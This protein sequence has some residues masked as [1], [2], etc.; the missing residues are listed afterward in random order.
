MKVKGLL[1]TVMV[2]LFSGLGLSEVKEF[3]SDVKVPAEAAMNVSQV[4]KHQSKVALYQ[5]LGRLAKQHHLAIY[6]PVIDTK[7]KLTYPCLSKTV[8]SQQVPAALVT[9]SVN[10]M[11]YLTKL[12]GPSFAKQLQQLGLDVKV[13]ALPWQLIVADFLFGNERSV[14][15]WALLLTFALSL[16][17][18]KVRQLKAAMLAR[19]LGGLAR[20][21]WMNLGQELGF[22][23]VATS[24]CLAIVVLGVDGG[25]W[26][27]LGKAFALQELVLTGLLAVIII[28]VNVFFTAVIK[29]LKPVA[30]MKNRTYSALLGNTWLLGILVASFLVLVA[31]E[32]GLN[33]GQ[34]VTRQLQELSC[35]RQVAN[36][37]KIT[38]RDRESTHMDA[39][40]HEIDAQFVKTNEHQ[41]WRFLKRFTGDEL[42]YASASRLALVPDPKQQSKEELRLAKR[43]IY[44]NRGFQIKNSRLGQ[45]YTYP[46]VTGSAPITIYLPADVRYQEDM[47]KDLVLTEWFSHTGLR[48]S[49]FQVVV[50]KEKRKLFT[51]NQANQETS[52]QRSSIIKN[53]IFVLLHFEKLDRFAEGTTLGSTV[54]QQALFKQALIQKHGSRSGLDRDMT[55]YENVAQTAELALQHAKNRLVGIQMAGIILFIIQ[56]FTL[57]HYLGCRYEVQLR[58][59]M[60]YRLFRA[61][62]KQPLLKLVAPLLT[63]LGML[64]LLAHHQGLNQWLLLALGGIY[65][66][67]T[68]SLLLLVHWRFSQQ[69]TTVLKGNNDIL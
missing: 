7:G 59:I 5:Q 50:L 60:L 25:Q 42:V 40:S 48:S 64:F 35:W 57:Y 15:V 49:D 54:S 8:L 2:I 51:F 53:P 43:L 14:A 44:G 45:Q 18:L 22:L 26:T 20:H 12:P 68:V 47:I 10:G 4:T 66:L 38:W 28:M 33:T 37:A 65:G 1:I 58:A 36:F 39:N 29:V 41:H 11:Y 31:A 52:G 19:S 30:V 63:G 24:G 13:A 46:K 9:S 55:D 69:L 62:S 34:Q 16:L 67:M 56:A 3:G 23:L 61:S 32:A 17:A 27:L 6:K 21:S